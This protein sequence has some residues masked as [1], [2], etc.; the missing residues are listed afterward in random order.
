MKRNIKSPVGLNP[1]GVGPKIM[2]PVIPILAAGIILS[3]IDPAITFFY[4]AKLIMKTA[5]IALLVPGILFYVLALVQFIKGFPEGR[6]I[7]G[8]IYRF[9]RNPIY[10]SWIMF[11]FPAI[12]LLSNNW[13]FLLASPVMLYFLLINIG[14]EEVELQEIFGQEYSS[15]RKKVGRII[16]L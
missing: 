2:K 14:S 12:S 16:S 11:L 13:I 5:G 9:S 7:T 8:G 1:K 10:V 6:L 15:Y 3:I 4:P